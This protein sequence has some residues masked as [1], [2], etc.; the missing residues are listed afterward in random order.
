MPSV[1]MAAIL[2]RGRWVNSA[3][4]NGLLVESGVTHQ[5]TAAKAFVEWGNTLTRVG[6]MGRPRGPGHMGRPNNM[7]YYG[8]QLSYMVWVGYGNR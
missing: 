6:Q 4:E 1:K 5:P 2:S 3:S 7:V 8:M